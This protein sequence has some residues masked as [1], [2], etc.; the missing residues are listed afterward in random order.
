VAHQRLRL[1]ILV[2]ASAAAAPRVLFV[3]NSYVFVNDLP[4]IFSSV[5]GSAGHAPYEI[6]SAT[7]GGA[8]LLQHLSSPATLKLIDEGN[9]DI[10]IV[11]AHSQEAAASELDPVERAPTNHQ[12][13]I[14]S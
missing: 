7:P 13:T 6:K 10:V 4:Q 8:T 1:S 3:G 9:W 5:A 14:R 11:Q 12:G 2:L